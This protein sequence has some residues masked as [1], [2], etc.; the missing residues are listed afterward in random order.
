MG[1][2]RQA[3]ARLTVPMQGSPPFWGCTHYIVV[4]VVA[5]VQV[6]LV[7]YNAGWRL[8][9]GVKARLAGRR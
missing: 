5:E 7:S 9:E 8:V 6:H 1:R 3:C 2:K 4:L